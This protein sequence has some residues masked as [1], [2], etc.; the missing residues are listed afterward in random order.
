MLADSQAVFLFWRK[1]EVHLSTT[2]KF[3]NIFAL[4]TEHNGVTNALFSF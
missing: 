4:F 3:C 1:S 2:I